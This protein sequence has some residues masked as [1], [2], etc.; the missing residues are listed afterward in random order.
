MQA[1]QA[2]SS[3]RSSSETIVSTELEAMAASMPTVV[4]PRPANATD[5]NEIASPKMIGLME[6]ISVPSRRVL[7]R[8]VLAAVVGHQ[9]DEVVLVGRELVLWQIAAR[10]LGRVL[11][12]HG[13]QPERAVVHVDGGIA[14]R[15]IE[16]LDQRRGVGVARLDVG[17]GVA[18]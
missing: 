7:A 8:V 4:A 14:R 10:D 6:R 16:H 1:R 13:A 15:R 12:L 11:L 2:S 18:H 9:P 17:L 3:A 5:E